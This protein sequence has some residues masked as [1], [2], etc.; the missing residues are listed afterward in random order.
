MSTNRTT[1]AA[2]FPAVSTARVPRLAHAP[3]KPSAIA[4]PAE[5]NARHRQKAANPFT[6][7]VSRRCGART[8]KVW[9]RLSAVLA[10]VDTRRAMMFASAAEASWEVKRKTVA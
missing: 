3:V 6:W 5:V 7:A 2:R 8:P 10:T 1:V 9:L 4:S